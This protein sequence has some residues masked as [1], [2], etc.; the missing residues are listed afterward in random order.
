MII[1]GVPLAFA[2]AVPRGDIGIII[3]APHQPNAALLPLAEI[4]AS[5]IA[6][7]IDH[8]A[9]VT[10]LPGH[11]PATTRIADI[12]KPIEPQAIGNA[13]SR[14]QNTPSVRARQDRRRRGTSLGGAPRQARQG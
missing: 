6:D 1:A 7:R 11:C 2:N 5:V 12:K 13:Y 3:V 8:A 14:C 4:R 10:L 9:E